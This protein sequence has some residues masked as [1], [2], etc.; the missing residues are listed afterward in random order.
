MPTSGDYLLDTNI[1]SAILDAD[2][3]LSPRAEVSRPLF[4]PSIVVGEL[5][6]GAAKSSRRNENT[7]RIERYVSAVHVLPIDADTARLFGDVKMRLRVKGRK[8]P[9]ADIWIAC[10]ALQHGLVLVTRDK[11]F[12]EVDG[13]TFEQW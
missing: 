6:Y 4:V 7:S 2:P 5:F 3:A 9:D 11:H 1:V 12:H 8:I 13:L 10:V